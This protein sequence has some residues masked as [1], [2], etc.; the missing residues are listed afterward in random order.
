MASQGP[1]QVARLLIGC[2]RPG[3]E[4]SRD[5]PAAVAAVRAIAGADGA[6][7]EALL[8]EGLLP[9]L[10]AALPSP[11][12]KVR[13]AGYA[14]FVGEACELLCELAEAAPERRE[15]V[16]GAGALQALQATRATLALRPADD[17]EGQGV[18]RM[19]AEM[20]GTGRAKSEGE[21]RDR[22]GAAV[23][24]ALARLGLQE[25]EGAEGESVHVC[26]ACGKQGGSSGMFRC[27]GCRAA[28]YCGA[29]CQ[30]AHWKKHRPD[31]LKA[32][33]KA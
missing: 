11:P 3:S 5:Q 12:N 27:G 24:R 8:Q 19:V 6:A 14:E 4:C 30:R 21:L 20:F 23:G 10:C 31:C 2:L 15:V 7:A 9:A 33:G 1:G 13:V 32:Q 26:A 25:R 22:A 18:G 17:E 28:R 16:L 29:S